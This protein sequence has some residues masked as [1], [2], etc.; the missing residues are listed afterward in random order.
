MTSKVVEFLDSRGVTTLDLTP[1]FAGRSPDDLTVSRADS[2]P[3]AKVY[4]E[5]ADLL[6]PYVERLRTRAAVRF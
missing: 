1:V 2:H 3:N 5:V 6:A 4:R